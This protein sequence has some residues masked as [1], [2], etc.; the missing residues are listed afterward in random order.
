MIDSNRFLYAVIDCGRNLHLW[1]VI[2]VLLLFVHT[3]AA[4][5]QKPSNPEQ[6]RD[7]RMDQFFREFFRDLNESEERDDRNPIGPR[8]DGEDLER[9]REEFFR[10]FMDRDDPR[11]ELF[12]PREFRAEWEA[13]IRERKV[14]DLERQSKKQLATFQELTKQGRESVVKV[15]K[16]E[17]QICL[18]TFID[19]TGH[20]VTKLTEV[21][22]ADKI[23][24]ELY[25]GQ[26]V[27]GSRQGSD[28]SSDL[29]LFFVED[30]SS[31]PVEWSQ[32]SLEVG[33]I[34]VSGDERG[35]PIA[36]GITS[37]LPR[38]LVGNNRAFLG[39][40][41]IPHNQGVEIR[42]VERESAAQAAGLK[43]GDVVLAINDLQKPD[44]NSFVNKIREFKPGDQIKLTILRDGATM[45]VS[46]VLNG[47]SVRG[48]W[49]ARLNLM[50]R[51][52]AIPSDRRS[53]F[54]S[55]LQHDTP[56]LPEQCGGP[57]LDLS[58]RAVGINIAREGRVS[59][60]ALPQAAVIAAV[61][62]MK[63]GQ[64]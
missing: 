58:G 42:I 19:A 6:D 25:D 4:F 20:F 59:S 55:A 51:M 5:A 16:Q 24:V 37:V 30:I 9:M 49:A 21:G 26:R 2:I 62:K 28:Q 54:Q 43:K 10:E 12:D 39:V 60:Y 44:V 41:P 47:V 33:S 17:K 57:L 23:L 18:G 53:E 61:K 56:L 52:G 35:E 22:D 8:L 34:V 48:D 1:L 31:I 63:A 15:L 64:N 3:G 45:E 7:K 50:N 11:W 46:P 14:N 32:Q 27:T 13:T 36:M 40:Q 29:A 38:S